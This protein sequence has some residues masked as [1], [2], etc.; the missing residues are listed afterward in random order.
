M[1][2]YYIKVNPVIIYPICIKLGQNQDCFN[3]RYQKSNVCKSPKSLCVKPYH[4]HKKGCPNYGK[5]TLCPPDAPMFDEIFD[6]TKDIYCVYYAYDI[7]SHME[8]MKKKH[9]DWSDRQL[10]NVLY[11]QGT[12]KKL[13]R[14]KIKEFLKEYEPLGYEVISP[15]ATGVDATKTLE[16]AGIILEWPPKNKSYRIAF[17]GVPKLGKSLKN[18][19]KDRN[20]SLTSF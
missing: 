11:W 13:H 10:R 3:C 4:G 8:K 14:E 6:M 1:Q 15:E 16:N 9:P 12:A 7:K 17:A 20:N 2:D 5:Y 18:L 19:P